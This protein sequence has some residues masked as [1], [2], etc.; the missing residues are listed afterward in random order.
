MKILATGFQAHLDTG[1]TA[2]CH[3]WRVTLRSGER[4]GFTDHDVAL[5]FDGTTFEAQAGFTG[6]EIESALG[7]AVDNLEASGALASAKISEDRLHAG[8]FDHASVELWRV[9]WQDP[10]QRAMLRAGHLGEVTAGGGAFTAELRG[11]AHLFNQT[12]GRIYQ[13]GCDAELG[14]ARCGINLELPAYQGSG[15]ITAVENASLVV[16]GVNAFASGWFTCGTVTWVSGPNSGRFASIRAHRLQGALARIN[17]LA[18]LPFTTSV[19]EA[20]TLRAGC[21]KQLSTCKTKFANT[22]NHRGF[23]HMPGNDFI[24]TVPTADDPKNNGGRRTT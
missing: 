1:T 10:A 15:T 11:L 4:M 18:T 12:Q 8:E 23:P 22:V 20:V 13:Y 14:D 19:G 2:L 5:V 17:L 21:D 7:L 6:S 9:N 16:S 3:C 24:L